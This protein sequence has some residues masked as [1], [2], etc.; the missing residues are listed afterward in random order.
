MTFMYP[1]MLVVAPA[2]GLGLVVAYRWLQRQRKRTLAAAGLASAVP[3]MPVPGTRLDWARIR[4]HVPPMLFLAALILL[5]LAVGRP[6]ATVPVP[7]ASGTVIL[8]FDV[9]NSMAPRTSPPPGSPPRR[10]PRSSF[11]QDAA[12]HSRHRRRRVRPGRADHPAAV[13][14]P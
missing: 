13:G 5:L 2:A 8:A 6:Q 1:V 14:R 12:G 10:R 9:S 3:S 4:R 7:Q 11:V